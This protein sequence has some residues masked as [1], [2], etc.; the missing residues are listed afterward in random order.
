MYARH[1]LVWLSAEGWLAAR[2]SAPV[3]HGAA[4]QRWQDND[5]PLVARRRDA[6]QAS[7]ESNRSLS[8]GL[9]L[10]PDPD[11]GVKVRI[12]LQVPAATVARATDPLPLKDVLPAL[13]DAWRAAMTA[14]IDESVGLHLRVFGSTALQALTGLPY[15]GPAS[16]IDLLFYPQTAQ[17]LRAGLALL[18]RHSAALPLDGEIVFPRG[19]AVAWKEWR[20]A[21]DSHARVLVKEIDTVRLV[22]P[23]LLL[24]TLGDV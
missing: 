22:P 15:I 3:E 16:D 18:A 21:Q 20:A 9:P 12:A 8:L 14:L 1:K 5:W 2:A 24:A 11:S 6:G 17:Q 19:E 13:P 23:N 10:P 7:G 4:L